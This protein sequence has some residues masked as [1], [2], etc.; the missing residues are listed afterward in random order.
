MA[1]L[2]HIIAVS[3][4][5]LTIMLG[6][7]KRLLGKRSKRISTLLSLLLMGVFLLLAGSSASIV[8][9]A[10]VSTL[11]IASGYY[12]RTFKPLNLIA[13][14]AAITAWAN[15]F[16]I[17]SDA[18]W[19]LSFLAFYGVMVLAPLFMTRLPNGWQHSLV[20]M[21][22]LESLC[23]ETMTIPFVL[24]TFGQVSFI[25]LVA[26]VL[27]TTLVPLAML[28][29]TVA[30]LGGMFTGAVSGWLAWPARLL[31]TYMLDVAHILSRIPYVFAQHLALSVSQ[32]VGMYTLTAVVTF[33]LWHKTK[34]LRY[35][36]ITDRKQRDAQ[37]V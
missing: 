24:H 20:V 23:A 8:R 17:W 27:I 7:S 30:G 21:V 22:A 9:A 36:T 14:A 37:G 26:N 10:I 16:Y 3:G 33:A 34:L 2:T 28:L 13:L 25:G 4:Y 15:P 6:A 12:G 35:A 19:Y 1:G 29:G 5:N 32:M 11:S 18:S 31:L